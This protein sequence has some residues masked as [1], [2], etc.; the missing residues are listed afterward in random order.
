M[1]NEYM[2]LLFMVWFNMVSRTF[3][4][5]VPKLILVFLWGF[6]LFYGFFLF[7][8]L[9]VTSRQEVNLSEFM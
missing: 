4:F 8:S 6:V 7:C 1:L 5:V 9:G 3:G 2:Y